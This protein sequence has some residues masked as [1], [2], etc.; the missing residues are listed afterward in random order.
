M[1]KPKDREPE[2][3]AEDRKRTGYP[4]E[5][6]TQSNGDDG[7]ESASETSNDPDGGSGL[8]ASLYHQQVG[9][10]SGGHIED[11]T[12]PKSE[13]VLKCDPFCGVSI[14]VCIITAE[15]AVEECR[16][17]EIYEPYG[18]HDEG[19]NAP[20]AHSDVDEAGYD[21]PAGRIVLGW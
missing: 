8:G 9:Q 3:Y 6:H 17:R 20:H 21:S 4:P 16:L 19:S 11:S 7:E 2:D 13:Q 15:E 14:G 12:H 5:V 18:H 10:E 1:S